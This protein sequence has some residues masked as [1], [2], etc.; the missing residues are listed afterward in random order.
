MNPFTIIITRLG[1]RDETQERENGK[2][3]SCV[4]LYFLRWEKLTI[5]VPKSAGVPVGV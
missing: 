5:F 2:A 4:M 3:C 1:S